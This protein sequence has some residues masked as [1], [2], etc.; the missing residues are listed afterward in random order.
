MCYVKQIKTVKKTRKM[1]NENTRRK[2]KL[3]RSIYLKIV[4]NSLFEVYWVGKN[5]RLLVRI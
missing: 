3:H 1:L 4:V 5:M 2:L